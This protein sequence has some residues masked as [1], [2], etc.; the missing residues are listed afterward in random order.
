LRYCY[1]KADPIVDYLNDYR[2]RYGLKVQ[3][4]TK[5]QNMRRVKQ[6]ERDDGYN[7]V[8]NDQRGNYMLCK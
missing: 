8:M 7:F 3:F 4:N 6:G 5:V 1:R 2:E